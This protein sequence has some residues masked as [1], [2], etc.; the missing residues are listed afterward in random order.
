MRPLIYS[1]IEQQVTKGPIQPSTPREE[2]IALREAF[3]RKFGDSARAVHGPKAAA[4]DQ[5]VLILDT[6]DP[7]GRRLSGMTESEVAQ[8]RGDAQAQAVLVDLVAA[9]RV[10]VVETLAA[11]N[12]RLSEMLEEP[13]TPEH[14]WLVTVASQGSNLCQ[15]PLHGE[16]QARTRSID[17]MATAES[18]DN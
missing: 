14:F 11:I 6:N 16:F 10:D 12:P 17:R 2:A 9:P 5:V 15:Y 7:V 1:R 8:A 13:A 4:E 3:V 18:S